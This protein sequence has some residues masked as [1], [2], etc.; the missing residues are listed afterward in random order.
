LNQGNRLCDVCNQPNGLISASYLTKSWIKFFMIDKPIFSTNLEKNFDNNY[1]I[2]PNCLNNLKIGEQ[3]INK[4]IKFQH[5]KSYRDKDEEYED[6]KVAHAIRW[7]GIKVLVLP[8]VV[9]GDQIRINAF[10]AIHNRLIELNKCLYN[11]PDSLIIAQNHINEILL[12]HTDN[13]LLM[14]YVFCTQDK[15]GRP[16]KVN[17]FIE[18]VPIDRIM[19]LS[20]TIT[21]INT[22]Q[23]IIVP[24]FAFDLSK[25]VYVFSRE[26]ERKM[27]SKVKEV[28]LILSLMNSIFA[29][30]LFDVNTLYNSFAS[31]IKH[32][33]FAKETRYKIN[34]IIEMI[35]TMNQLLE[36]LGKIHV[37]ETHEGI[38][39]STENEPSEIKDID[40]YLKEKGAYNVVEA[41]SLFLVGYLMSKVGRRQCTNLGSK[42]IF[43]KINYDGMTFN[44]VYHLISEVEGKLG[45][46]KIRDYNMPVLNR[47]HQGLDMIDKRKWKILP[48]EA[49]VYIM[50]GFA[51]QM[52]YAKKKYEESQEDEE[53]VGTVQS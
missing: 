24:H 36:F 19:M 32:A 21:Q 20:N 30:N 46:Y 49:V 29:E 18:N 45:A 22:N 12:H 38:T 44:Q 13:I 1:A 6:I 50:S 31:R 26:K 51:F 35:L 34:N 53:I 14:R 8:D 42:P 17:M 15:G 5:K 47:L 28:N 2:C 23:D 52:A 39:M 41:Q 11:I 16:N 25:F 48:S 40:A 7:F 3:Y 37:I 27:T 10:H 33:W 43:K 9:I 4:S